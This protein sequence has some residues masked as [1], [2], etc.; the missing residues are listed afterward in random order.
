MTPYTK[1]FWIAK[2][3]DEQLNAFVR[4]PIKKTTDTHKDPFFYGQKCYDDTITSFAETVKLKAGQC[5][6]YVMQIQEFKEKK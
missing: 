2:D 6:K 3:C 1:Y 4:K 5:K